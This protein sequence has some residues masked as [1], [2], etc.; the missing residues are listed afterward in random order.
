MNCHSYNTFFEVIA[1]KTRLKILETL[2]KKPLSVSQICEKLEE[3]Q[4][5][6]SHNLKKLYDCNFLE[7][8]T[9]GKQRIYTLNKDTISP[10]MEL[11]KKHIQYHCPKNCQCGGQKC[12]K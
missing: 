5:K 6:I 2:S 3:E 1:N 7:V 9:K 4:S 12:K 10:L 11:V 8:E